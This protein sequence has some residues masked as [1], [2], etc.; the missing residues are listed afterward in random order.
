MHSLG[1]RWIRD[2]RASSIVELALL[3]PIFS[4]VLVGA[5]Q[6]GMLCYAAIELSEAARAGVA[7]GSQSPGKASDLSGM[8]TAATNAAPNIS[9]MTAT[10]TQFWACSNV[11]TTHYTSTPTC[12]SGN[13]TIH[14]VQ[15]STSLIATTSF[16]L[17]GHPSSYTLTGL[18]IMRVL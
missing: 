14:Y 13:H 7:Y 9:G 3:V 5:A 8:Q 4:V 12:T 18:A 11:T 6:F 16:H 10:A 1:A 15:V 17:S 2:S